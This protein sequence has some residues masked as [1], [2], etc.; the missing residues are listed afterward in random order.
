MVPFIGRTV[1]PPE[2]WGFEAFP[3]V[4]YLFLFSLFERVDLPHG[5]IPSPPCLLTTLVFSQESAVCACFLYVSAVSVLSQIF[6]L[7]APKYLYIVS[8]HVRFP[9]GNVLVCHVCSARIG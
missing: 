7:D 2:T 5:V 6:W 1:S 3:R 9:V 8:C 4:V